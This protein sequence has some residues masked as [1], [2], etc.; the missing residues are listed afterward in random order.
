MKSRTLFIL[1]FVGLVIGLPA[2]YVIWNKGHEKHSPEHPFHAEDERHE[3]H[4]EYAEH[5]GIELMS[6]EMHELGLKTAV[7]GG[8]TIDIHISLAGEI[9]VNE[10]RMA[11]IVPRVEG[12]VIAV[13]KT[14]GDVVQVGEVIAVIESRELADA[15]AEYLESVERYE[16]AK[17]TFGREENLWKDKISSTEEYLDKKHAMI[18][19]NIAK[20]SAQQKLLAIG[21]GELYLANLPDEPDQLLT[22]FEIKAPFRGTI[23]EKHI[24][25]GEL[26]GTGSATHIIADLDSVWV[27]L[28]VYPR[29]LKHIKENQDVVI[30][31]DSEIPDI[32][33]V[34]S[35]VGPIIGTESR[36][37]LAR[38]VLPNESGIF[39]PGLF[40]TGNVAVSKTQVKIVVPKDAVQSLEGRK[41][42][43]VK[44]EH[45][46][47]PAFVEI[48]LENA[49]QIE[50]ISGL[51][52]GQEY[53]TEGAF[54]LKSKIV[55]STLGSHAGHGH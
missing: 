9:K 49:S 44:D 47:E 42:V 29:D 21:F 55:T 28:Q 31:A 12:V 4:E 51:N 40:V 1:L 6:E 33:G 17:L 26:V 38:A 18:E 53:V 23:I 43:F 41:C 3:N 11:H 32:H 50:I 20:R 46:F 48:G 15:K 22:R 39:K 34:I 35:Y 7:A 10:D 37:A 2:Y 16:I 25:L 27:D 13:N 52:P 19:A 8:G 24:V 45:G 5:E 30:S 54:T 36:S 14:L